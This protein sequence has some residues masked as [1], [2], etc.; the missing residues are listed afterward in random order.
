MPRPSHIVDIH[1]VPPRDHGPDAVHA[2]IA[3]WTDQGYLSDERGPGPLE[4]VRGGFARVR[5]DDPGATVLYANGQGGFRVSCPRCSRPLVDVF[6]PT[7]ITTCPGC[8]L[9]ADAE[10]LVTN[11]PVALGTASLVLIDVADGAIQAPLPD[12]WRLVWRRR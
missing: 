3:A 10:G 2:L 12:G 7:G 1:L 4:L 5:A 8:G 11:P 6:A 9:A